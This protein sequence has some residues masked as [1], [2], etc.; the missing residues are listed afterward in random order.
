MAIQRRRY[1]W[2]NHAVVA[3]EGDK[4]KRV[5]ACKLNKSIYGLEQASRWWNDTLVSFLKQFDLEPIH[6]DGCALMR[7]DNESILIIAIYV[8][9][10]LACSNN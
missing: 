5:L 3:A 7:T 10:D 6:S 9:D 1:G 8:D 2:R 4:R